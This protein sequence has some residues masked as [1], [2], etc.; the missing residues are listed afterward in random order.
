M[1]LRESS[2][3]Q[4]PWT[5]LTCTM[6]RTSGSSACLDYHVSLWEV[7]MWRW[8]AHNKVYVEEKVELP[9]FLDHWISEDVVQ[10]DSV[11]VT[12]TSEISD[13]G[14]PKRWPDGLH[15]LLLSVIGMA[16]SFDIVFDN[17][18]CWWENFCIQVNNVIFLSFDFGRIWVIDGLSDILGHWFYF[19]IAIFCRCRS[20]TTWTRRSNRAAQRSQWRLRSTITAM[21]F[22]FGV[23]ELRRYFAA[24]GWLAG[25]R[26]HL[27]GK[28]F[29]ILKVQIQVQEW[30][31]WWDKYK[32]GVTTAWNKLAYAW[33]YLNGHL[34]CTDLMLKIDVTGW[35]CVP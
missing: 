32:L 18:F 26:A 11:D 35:Q 17:R 7:V 16:G 25:E 9:T 3:F 13:M 22:R 33:R 27:N 4:K 29:Q 12:F 6:F 19:A 24:F 1:R 31:D 10:C 34:A 15:L 14:Q 23:S 20:C 21:I 30:V 28:L 2:F 5:I 8:Y